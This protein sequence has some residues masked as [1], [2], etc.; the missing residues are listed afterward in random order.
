LSSASAARW[1]SSSIIAQSD[2]L[3]P[4]PRLRLQRGHRAERAAARDQRHDVVGVMPISLAN[5]SRSLSRS[6]S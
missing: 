1:P 4:R 3:N 2:A 6:G 5:V